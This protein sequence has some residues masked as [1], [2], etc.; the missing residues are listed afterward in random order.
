MENTT[1]FGL[2]EKKIGDVL[3]RESY[4]IPK[5]QRPYEWD[6]ERWEEL[7]DD[8]IDAN[9][10]KEEHFFGAMYFVKLDANKLRIFDGQQRLLTLNVLLK[11]LYDKTEDTSAKSIITNLLIK[12]LGGR[13][14]DLRI[15]FDTGNYE[16]YQQLIKE[17][18][19]NTSSREN[20]EDAINQIIN[21]I[22]K[23]NRMF[24][25][26]GKNERLILASYKFFA[27]KIE[28]KQDPELKE[29]A[30]TIR[31]NFKILEIIIKDSETAYEIFE[32]LN[33]RGQKL[34]IDD[35]FIN[36]LYELNVKDPAPESI[37]I[38]LRENTEEDIE[39]YLRCFWL[40]NNDFLRKK[41][42]FREFK[43]ALIK[44]DS[45]K[46]TEFL[47]KLLKEVETY[48]VLIG[49]ENEIFRDLLPE[50]KNIIEDI[51]RLRFKQGFPMLLSALV[52]RTEPTDREKIKNLFRTY[53]DLCIRNY[54]ICGINPNEL[55]EQYS[56]LAIG[57]R[58]GMDIDEICV[59][60]KS[61]V[62]K[63]EQVKSSLVD[64]ELDQR[65][66]RYILIKL[67]NK[68][69]LQSELDLDINNT[70]ITLEHIIPQE[71]SAEW[72]QILEQNE[73]SLDE[74]LNKLGN[75]T[76]ISGNLN[77]SINND[78]LYPEK[79]AAYI[80]AQPLQLNKKTFEGDGLQTFGSELIR[81]RAA[82]IAAL[83]IDNHLFGNYN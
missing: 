67:A 69:K 72:K 73:M 42:L 3:S 64:S 39:N 10:K 77:S 37:R 33:E 7:W 13:N 25:N 27:K 68:I 2:D 75:L 48:Y 4:L 78:T 30:I 83:I 76:L 18:I 38:K 49:G 44:M 81:K 82:I 61:F 31:D 16:K 24:K 70:N 57:I 62:I 58:K 17:G 50:I 60:L 26:S 59:Q 51:N 1:N 56:K 23:Y 80:N 65:V 53:R 5:N 47:E 66:C 54:S 36:L 52:S 20:V 32:T 45:N 21:P 55:E 79:R 22:I 11:V 63:D 14:Q 12:E 29:L 8:L 28:N 40:S 41:I 34:Q 71:P 19:T 9:R 43:K 15:N 35:L 74:N 46:I 6:R